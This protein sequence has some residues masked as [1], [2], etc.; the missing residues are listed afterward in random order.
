MNP[1]Y[2][3]LLQAHGLFGAV[4]LLTF[5][6]AAL[7]KKG[8]V[9]HIK[10]GKGYLLA[11]LGIVLTAVPMSLLLAQAG[12]PGM[13]TFFGYLVVITA[14]SMWLGWRAPKLKREQA[15]FRNNTY[16]GVALLNLA[17]AG[18]VLSIGLQ[19]QQALLIGFSIVGALIGAQML[20]RKWRPQSAP[21]WWLQEHYSAMIGCG[22]ATHIAFLAIALERWIRVLGLQP[23]A[24]YNLL[25]WFLPLL[26]SVVVRVWMARKYAPPPRAQ[27]S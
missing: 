24:W 23:P 18:V 2:Q 22:V 20:F 11:M 26:L 9:L 4:A 7:A 6:I 10:V 8:S 15:A 1:L 25:A 27:R 14:T 13:A 16:V 3:H 12:K 19:R 17:S 5:W 21:R